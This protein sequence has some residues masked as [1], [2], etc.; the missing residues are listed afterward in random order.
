MVLL[1][2]S[3][4]RNTVRHLIQ[5]AVLVVKVVALTPVKA[6][7]LTPVR[8]VALTPVKVV[9]ILQAAALVV[10]RIR[11]AGLAAVMAMAKT[12]KAPAVEV[13]P[14]LALNGPCLPSMK[15]SIQMA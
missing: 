8:V 7:A 5:V 10:V 14:V 2:K 13:A 6:V 11:A 1:V 9:A 3:T 12:V 15:A 4:A